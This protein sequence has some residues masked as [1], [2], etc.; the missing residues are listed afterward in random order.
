MSAHSS[1]DLIGMYTSVIP[2]I[3][4]SECAS[5][6]G[7]A[8]EGRFTAA[9]ASTRGMRARGAAAERWGIAHC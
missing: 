9:E 8:S 6:G 1:L 4:R 7:G 2:A 5:S 3:G